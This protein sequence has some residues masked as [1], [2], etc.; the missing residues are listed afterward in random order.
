MLNGVK[1]IDPAHPKRHASADT[2][3]H[4]LLA[5]CVLGL[6]AALGVW[7]SRLGAP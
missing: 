2:W 3:G 1:D 4:R 7:I 5:I 6:S